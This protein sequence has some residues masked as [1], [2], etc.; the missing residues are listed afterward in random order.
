MP[1]PSQPPITFDASKDSLFKAAKCQ[2]A[3]TKAV[4]DQIVATVEPRVANWDNTIVPIIQDENKKLAASRYLCFYKSTSPNPDL[5]NASNT[6]AGLFDDADVELYARADIFALI[7]VVKHQ[8]STD[9]SSYDTES[10]YYLKKLNQKF[11]QNGCGLLDPDAK[12]KFM[13]C[14]RRIKELERQCNKNH[15]DESTKVWFT[16]E[17]VAG[18]PESFLARLTAGED[19]EGVWV[20]TKVP[21][22]GPILRHAKKEDTRRKMFYT[23]QN[24]MPD[25]VELFRELILLRDEAARLLGYPN[26]AALRIGDKMMQDP[27][28][29][30]RLLDDLE[31]RLV[32]EGAKDVATLLDIKR[33]EAGCDAESN[34]SQPEPCLERVFFWDVAYLANIQD[35][36]EK[37]VS[38]DIS[39]Y[40]E[41]YHTLE[42]LLGIFRRSFDVEF[43]RISSQEQQQAGCGGPLV[44]HDDVL[45]YAV[46]DK[47]EE[48]TGDRF[49]GYAYL[50]LHPRQGKYTHSGHYPL[51]PV[52]TLYAMLGPCCIETLTRKIIRTSPTLMA[53]VTEPPRYSS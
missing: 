11:T 16:R 36:E 41:L 38:I 48:V 33:R 31:M 10:Q 13:Q 8:V 17:E 28:A 50:D 1:F 49:M 4:W 46:W 51:R 15:H 34:K 45:M 14:Q 2:L 37:S 40:Y 32:P 44:W 35:N 53:R 42:S 12:A 19:D 27:K 24:R 39:D 30:R 47:R 23:I 6:V 22:S 26:H 3:A 43:I 20:S 7:D 25:N 5:R 18:V 29:V 21:Q 52:S 9:P